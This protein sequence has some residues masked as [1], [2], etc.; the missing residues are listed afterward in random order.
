[1]APGT[2]SAW[3]GATKQM[4]H[5]PRQSGGSR[6]D[7]ASGGVLDS[8]LEAIDRFEC[9]GKAMPHLS[10]VGYEGSH[11]ADHGRV[12]DDAHDGCS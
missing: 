2:K 4:Q 6:R 11:R 1:V 5:Q 7:L 12:R 9:S 8:I 3:E 10:C